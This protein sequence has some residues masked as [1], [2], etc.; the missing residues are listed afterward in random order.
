MKCDELV[1]AE[2][3][4]V[5]FY[6][7][8][9]FKQYELEVHARVGKWPREFSFMPHGENARLWGGKCQIRSYV[10]QNWPKLFAWLNARDTVAGLKAAEQ[11]LKLKWN[12]NQPSG[13]MNA[14]EYKEVYKDRKQQHAALE[15]YKLSRD[16]FK[17]HGR[18]AWNVVK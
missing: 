2:F 9:T 6:K 16:S 7:V 10:A 15:S 12:G 1:A 14:K 17:T 13:S 5:G 11:I 4:I 18:S 8:W 3:L